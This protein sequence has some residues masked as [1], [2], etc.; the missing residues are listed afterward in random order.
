MKTNM[1]KTVILIADDEKAATASKSS[2]TSYCVTKG[3]LG[4]SVVIR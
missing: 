4:L 1:T 3:K 2:E